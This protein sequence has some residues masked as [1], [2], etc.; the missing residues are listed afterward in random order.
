M[1]FKA[2]KN[3]KGKPSWFDSALS[4]AVSDFAKEMDSK[5]TSKNNREKAG[6]SPGASRQELSHSSTQKKDH[7]KLVKQR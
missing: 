3:R 5:P 2:I 1:I 7:G 6:S 4:Q